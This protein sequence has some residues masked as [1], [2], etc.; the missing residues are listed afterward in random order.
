MAIGLATWAALSIAAAAA[1]DSML[2]RMQ[3]QL[4]AQGQELS[5]LMR[6]VTALEDENSRLRSINVANAEAKMRVATTSEGGAYVL[7]RER[8]R[9]QLA[10]SICAA[11]EHIPC[12]CAGT[13]YFGPATATTLSAM[14]A[15]TYVTTAGVGATADGYTISSTW[16]NEGTSFPIICNMVG[17]GVADPAPSVVKHCICET[18]TVD[19]CRWTADGDCSVRLTV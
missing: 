5:L 3:R 16:F 8:S 14:K 12:S 2:A 11:S 15:G 13:I 6:K 1:D 10:E 18:R 9:R 4:D 19:C 7:P 17:L